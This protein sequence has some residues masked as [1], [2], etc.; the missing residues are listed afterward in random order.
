M[1]ITARKYNKHISL[2]KIT[3]TQDDF[4][5]GVILSKEVVLNTFAKVVQ[6]NS[7]RARIENTNAQQY[8]MQFAVRYTDVDFNVVGYNGVEYTVTSVTNIDEANRELIIDA[9]KAE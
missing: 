4:G 2:I 1:A 6:I 9:Q 7:S 5:K 3:Q 8:A